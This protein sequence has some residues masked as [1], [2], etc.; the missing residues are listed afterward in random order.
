MSKYQIMEDNKDLIP[1]EG[2]PIRKIWHNDEWYFSVIDVIEVLTESKSPKVY[3]S[4]L[5]ERDNQL[6][7]NCQRLKLMATDGRQRLTDCANTEGVF[8]IIMS[9]PSPK[10]EPLKLWMA[11]V[12]AERIE[13]TENPELSFERMTEIYR[14]KGRSE[15]WIKER[16]QSIEA[17]K[18]LTDEW[19]TR[20]VKEGQEYAILTATIAKGTFGLTPSEHSQLKGLEKQNLRDHM[21]PLELIFTSLSEEITRTITIKDDLQG[22]NDNHDAA[23]KGGQLAGDARKRLEKKLDISVVSANNFLNAPKDALPSNEDNSKE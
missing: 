18:R 13:E 15:E 7:T 5:K 17:R 4:K 21:T 23:H 10:A 9:V 12:S 1:L 16:F 19:K 20:G 14:A 8:R 11:Q 6:L 3:W 22:F 2:K